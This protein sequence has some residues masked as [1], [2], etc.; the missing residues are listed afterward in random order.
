MN[1]H[2]PANTIL[3]EVFIV[4]TIRKDNFIL[5][6]GCLLNTDQLL[7]FIDIHIFAKAGLVGI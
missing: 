4:I 7:K 1:F 2:K 6:I 5:M 3:V